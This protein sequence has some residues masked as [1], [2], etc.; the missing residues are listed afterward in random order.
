MDITVVKKGVRWMDLSRGGA[1]WSRG[2]E[3]QERPGGD[4]TCRASNFLV[5]RYG[6]NG[7]A[8]REE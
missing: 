5:A 8:G 3:I 2:R 6:R 4:W 7:L 1:Q